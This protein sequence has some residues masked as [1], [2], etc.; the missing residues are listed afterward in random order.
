MQDTLEQRIQELEE[1]ND[2]LVMASRFERKQMRQRN[3]TTRAVKAELE[4]ETDTDVPA[5]RRLRH[6]PFPYKEMFKY[7]A[8]ALVVASLVAIAVVVGITQ[9]GGMAVCALAAC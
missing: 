4:T 3:H 9:S 6:A 2:G 1:L 7:I 8:M 5:K